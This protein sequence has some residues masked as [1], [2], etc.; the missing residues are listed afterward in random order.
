M[1]TIGS[2]FLSAPIEE[3]ADVQVAPDKIK[4]RLSSLTDILD[5]YR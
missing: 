3:G 1:F 2:T 4:E 5:K